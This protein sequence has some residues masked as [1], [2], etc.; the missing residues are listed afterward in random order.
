[1]YICPTPNLKFDNLFL[2]HQIML[3]LE[4]P[5]PLYPPLESCIY[6]AISPTL[7][8]F[9]PLLKFQLLSW[10]KVVYHLL[11]PHQCWLGN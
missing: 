3:G 2:L 9:D 7:R 6:Q 10:A 11:P 5:F 8:M 1:M 4:W